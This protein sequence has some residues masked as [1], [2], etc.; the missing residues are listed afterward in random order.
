ME[1]LTTQ[2]IVTMILLF[3]GIIY[4]TA[5]FIY[6]KIAEGEQF[7]LAKYGQ[8]FGYVA[9]VAVT[10]YLATGALPNFEE[11][12]A[13]IFSAGIPNLDAILALATALLL[14]II[15]KIFKISAAKQQASQVVTPASPSAPAEV[16]K[17]GKGK[18]LGIYGGSAS[19]DTPKPS[20]SFDVN[21]VPR[22]FID[23]QVI[24]AGVAA[25]QLVIDGIIQKQWNPD[26]QGKE[27]FIDV[28]FTSGIQPYAI[29]VPGTYRTSGDHSVSI[30]MGYF[31]K[32]GQ[33]PTWVSIDNFKM[34]LTG[35]KFQ[36]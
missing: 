13:T 6:R 25:M 3:G 1:T 5:M 14:G 16:P 31:D 36:E 27:P 2:F 35:T 30:R 21:M 15:Q 18:I 7:D 11:I 8:T 12:L 29:Y 32:N 19:G 22:L 28:M 33:N 34:T 9:I 26:Q 10:A 4:V 24:E 17:Y 20:L 23:V